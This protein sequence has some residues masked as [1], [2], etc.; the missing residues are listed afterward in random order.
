MVDFEPLLFNGNLCVQ[1]S[2]ANYKRFKEMGLSV[3]DRVK[4]QYRNDVLCYVEL[5]PTEKYH[6]EGM[7]EAPTKCPLCDKDLHINNDTFLECTNK[8]CPAN[9]VGRCTNYLTK[10]GIKGIKENIINNLFENGFIKDDLSDLYSIDYDKLAEMDGWKEK[11]AQTLRAK[12]HSLDTVF[13]YQLVGAIGIPGVSLETTRAIFSMY[14]L[15]DL[16]MNFIYAEG[17]DSSW[18]YNN[19]LTSDM[20]RVK[21]M[22]VD[23]VSD[24]TADKI[25]KFVDEHKFELTDLSLNFDEIKSYKKYLK[26]NVSDIPSGL[27][28]VFSGFR[29]DDLKETL[30]SAGNK[31]TVSGV[32]NKT[33]ILVVKDKS[34]TTSKIEKANDLGKK[35]MDIDE[36]KSY[37]ELI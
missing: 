10:L 21:L 9:I 7:I 15:D 4:V 5:D 6:K 27:N 19:F 28:I 23:G 20:T 33:D 30:T 16:A 12:I 3:G 26:D 31:V 29:D 13:D 18:S 14:D 17:V 8:E 36:F 24:K 32:S 25:I 37:L 1:A 11:S 35:V 22:K 2:I 34:K